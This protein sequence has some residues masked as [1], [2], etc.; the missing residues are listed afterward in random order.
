MW[1]RKA[2]SPKEKAALK[3]PWHESQVNTKSAPLSSAG[4][5]QFRFYGLQEFDPALSE[6]TPSDKNYFLSYINKCQGLFQ[7]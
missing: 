2:A 7:N 3:D 6:T 4:I 5:S 1:H